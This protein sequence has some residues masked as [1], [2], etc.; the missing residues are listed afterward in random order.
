MGTYVLPAVV[1]RGESGFEI[2]ESPVAPP[3]PLPAS[4]PIQGAS[5]LI[6]EA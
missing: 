6:S 1:A 4:I 5:S 2:P 3:S